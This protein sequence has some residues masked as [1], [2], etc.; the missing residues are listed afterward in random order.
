MSSIKDRL[1]SD[2]SKPCNWKFRISVAL[3]PNCYIDVL[4]CSLCACAKSWGPRSSGK[5]WMVLSWAPSTE[6]CNQ[7]QCPLLCVRICNSYTNAYSP[8]CLSGSSLLLS[9][10]TVLCR[11]KCISFNC[12]QFA[13]FDWHSLRLFLHHISHLCSMLPADTT[14]KEHEAQDG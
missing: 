10:G 1:S 3:L 12:Q 11:R 2:R 8:L 14:S 6:I 5:K 9:C 7:I 4:E 13:W